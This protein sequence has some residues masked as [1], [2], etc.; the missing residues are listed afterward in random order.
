VIQSQVGYLV[1]LDRVSKRDRVAVEDE[2]AR[3][4]MFVAADVRLRDAIGV[5]PRV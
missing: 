5:D 1:P 4:L 2:G 3:L